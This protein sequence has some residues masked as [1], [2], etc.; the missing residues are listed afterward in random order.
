[1]AWL[2]SA[3]PRTEA[4]SAYLDAPLQLP[5]SMRKPTSPSSRSSTSFTSAGPPSV[6]NQFSVTTRTPCSPPRRPSSARPSTADRAPRAG[7]R[8]LPAITGARPAP[9]AAATSIQRPIQSM[10]RRRWAASVISPSSMRSVA[11]SLRR[12]REQSGARRGSRCRE[13]LYG[14]NTS[15]PGRS[16]AGGWRRATPS[17]TASP[18]PRSAPPAMARHCRAHWGRRCRGR[19]ARSTMTRPGLGL[20]PS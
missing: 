3:R 19:G 2:S 18:V 14:T 5:K 4:R 10:S 12:R 6:W 1:M 9:S 13:Q 16:R 15:R 7:R 11:D 17:A 8:L 20:G